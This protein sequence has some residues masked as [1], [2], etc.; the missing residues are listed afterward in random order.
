MAIT[1]EQLIKDIQGMEASYRDY[2]QQLAQ[3]TKAV[4]QQSGGIQYARMLLQ[5]MEAEEEET[6]EV[7]TN[8]VPKEEVSL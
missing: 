2:S 4:E 8:H 3:L 5:K 6:K 7:S 1:K